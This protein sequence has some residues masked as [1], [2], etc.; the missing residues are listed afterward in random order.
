MTSQGKWGDLQARV[1]SAVVMLAVGLVALWQGGI[2][3]HALVACVAGGM[4]WELTRL[5]AHDK[6]SWP[7]QMG[8]VVTLALFVLYFIPPFFALPILLAPVL[9]ALSGMTADR[10]RYALYAIGLLVACFGLTVLREQGGLERVLWLILLV[11]ATDIAGYFAGKMIGG[12]KFW[13]SLSPKK[14][15]SGTSAG[16]VAAFVVGLI[17]GGFWLGLISVAVSFASQLGDISESALKR[18][19]GV[20]DSSNLLPGHGG[21]LDRFDGLVAAALLVT[22]ISAFIGL[23]TLPN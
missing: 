19:A 11:V 20:K 6:P 21:L 14:T 16:W 22:L 1:L 13:P 7:I 12:P 8:A 4:I 18:R 15:W 9:V 10:L 5:I 3:F 23:P 2:L 17:F